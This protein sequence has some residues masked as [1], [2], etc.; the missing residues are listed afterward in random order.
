MFK[1]PGGPSPRA[2]AHELADFAELTAWQLGSVSW[3]HLARL[4]G[5]LDEQDYSDGVPEED[6]MDSVVQAAYEELQQRSESC[7]TGY[8]FQ[9]DA[10]GYTLTTPRRHVYLKSH[11]YKYLLLATRLNMNTNK[12]HAGIDGTLLFERLAAEMAR[13]YF[14]EKAESLVFG[15]ASD[16]S[17]FADRINYLCQRVGEGSSFVNR[18]SSL[19]RQRDGKLDVVVW[20]PFPDGLPGKFIGFGQCK[21]GTDYKD[22]LTMLQPDAF[23]R[24]WIASPL[25]F[26]PIRAFFVSEALHRESWYDAAVDAGLLFDRCR[27]VEFSEAISHEVAD[28]IISWTTAAALSTGLA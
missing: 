8:P 14:G 22:T 15:T 7:V 21:T 28:D 4:L 10:S 18:N 20:K 13:N 11:I 19:N 5:R 25:A 23:C 6:E 9:L 1:W 26:V 2:S 3:T 16:H 12:N 17:S 27:V 24:K